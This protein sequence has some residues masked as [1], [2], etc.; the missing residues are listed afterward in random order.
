VKVKVKDFGTTETEKPT[1]LKE[2]TKNL[3]QRQ[4]F[5]IVE[6]RRTVYDIFAPRAF[7]RVLVLLFIYI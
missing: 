4:C 2:I 5:N 7:K 6:N 3:H 1:D